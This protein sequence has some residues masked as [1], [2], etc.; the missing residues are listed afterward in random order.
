MAV[1]SGVVPV[2][3]GTTGT[4]FCV[5]GL[6][7]ASAIIWRSASLIVASVRMPPI[8]TTIALL[9][10]E[11]VIERQIRRVDIAMAPGTFR[12]V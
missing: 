7:M 5:M 6:L 8:L 2:C 12:L 10:S 1:P 9:I 11:K 3:V 4:G